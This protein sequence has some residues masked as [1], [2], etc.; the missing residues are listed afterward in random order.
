[1]TSES[2]FVTLFRGVG[3]RQLLQFVFDLGANIAITRML[4]P[5]EV[6]TY[7]VAIASVIIVQALR[8]AGVN[9]Y[10]MQTR[11][12]QPREVASALG[13]ALAISLTLGGGVLLAAPSIAGFYGT[14]AIRDVLIIAS[15]NFLFVPFHSVAGGLLARHLHLVAPANA[16]LLASMVAAIVGVSLAAFGLGATSLAWAS[17]ASTLAATLGMLWFARHWVQ[18][19]PRWQ[20]WKRIWSTT[21]W[22]LAGTVTNQVGGRLNEIVIGKTLGVDH[23][24]WL[25]RAELLPRLLWSY[26]A[27][28]LLGVLTPTMASDL[29]AGADPRTL[30]RER[31]RLFALIFVPMMIGLGTQSKALLMTLYGTQWANSIEPAFWVCVASAIS[32]QFV[33]INSMLVASGRMRDLFLITAI[34][35]IARI[36]VLAIFAQLSIL[37]TTRGLIL[38][39]IAYALSAMLVARRAKLLLW[40]DLGY[41]AGPSVS[42]AII[43]LLVGS[44]ISALMSGTTAYLALMVGGAVLAAAWL[45]TI[46]ILEPKLLRMVLQLV[47]PR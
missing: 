14:P 41:V 5:S 23:A 11:D 37:A 17:V 32:G 9:V 34:E 31:L 25:D 24:A 28:M 42:S 30:L 45:V 21:R 29:R 43:M 44:W 10:L 38:A 35:Q 46:A 47:R 36:A 20:G 19:R 39:A 8:T 16:Q 6:G 27:P 2:R 26:L 15:L 3:S 18:L 13:L 4:A 12:L 22:T 1:M 33:A 40:R 7:S